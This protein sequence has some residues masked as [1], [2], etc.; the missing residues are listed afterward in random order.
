[1]TKVLGALMMVLCLSLLGSGVANALVSSPTALSQQ[2]G[3]KGQKKHKKGKK[4]A[5]KPGKK[6]NRK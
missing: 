2:D 4:A 3:G 5:K 6:Q 1:M